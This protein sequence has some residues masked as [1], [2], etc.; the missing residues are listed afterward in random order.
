MRTTLGIALR[1]AHVASATAV[2][3]TVAFAATPDCGAAPLYGNSWDTPTIYD[4]ST[5]TGT[6]TNPRVVT[7]VLS[8]LAGIAYNNGQLYG[9]GYTTPSVTG[10]VLVR[11]NPATGANTIVGPTGLQAVFEGDLDFH[12]TTGGL[13]AIQQVSGQYQMFQIN[14]NTGTAFGLTTVTGASF[15]DLSAMAF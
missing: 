9:L 2:V 3:L 14:P 1:R 11:I 13:Y 6:A 15:L 7:P 4:V 12:P 5:A 10:T 8:N